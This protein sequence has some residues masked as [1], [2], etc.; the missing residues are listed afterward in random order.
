VFGAL[1]RMYRGSEL[2]ELYRERR[3]KTLPIHKQSHTH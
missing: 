2:S 3:N 1:R